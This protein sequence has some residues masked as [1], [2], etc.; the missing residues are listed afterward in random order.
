[1]TYVLTISHIITAAHKW[2]DR[3]VEADNRRAD[4]LNSIHVRVGLVQVRGLAAHW[5]ER[6]RSGVKLERIL[7]DVLGVIGQKIGL[8]LIYSLRGC[9]EPVGID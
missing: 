6:E 2:R 3:Q 4:R 8:V 5:V 1:M 7:I 9:A